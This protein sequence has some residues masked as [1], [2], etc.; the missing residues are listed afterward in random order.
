M[1]YSE[2]RDIICSSISETNPNAPTP[3]NN[4]AGGT[5]LSGGSSKAL[6]ALGIVSVAALLL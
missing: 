3:P 4:N 1:A 6:V 2:N 5:L